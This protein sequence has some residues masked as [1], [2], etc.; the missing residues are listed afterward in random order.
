MSIVFD[1]AIE[2]YDKTRALPEDRHNALI[3][4]LITETR[5]QPNDTV[6]E[7]GIGTGR[8]AL[9]VAEHVQ[10]LYG[11][12]LSQ[13]MMGALRRKITSAHA[14]IDLAQADA[15]FLPFPNAT[16]DLVYAVHVYHLVNQWRAGIAEAW[17]VVKPGGHFVV[18]F[19][20][21][22]ADSPNSRLRRQM[23]V[24]AK[25]LGV[26]TRRPGS[27][28]EEETLEEMSKWD[29]NPKVVEATVWEETE[30]PAKILEELDRQIY[31]ETW[32]IPR[33]KMDLITPRLRE[34][35]AETFGDTAEPIPTKAWERWLVASKA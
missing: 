24:F 10:R 28:S 27:Q 5:V 32:A 4:A 19:H 8:I 17:R 15:V 29:P 22:E 18:S 16:F 30:I 1:R 13:E 9:S 33:D 2:Y 35:A 26:D 11:I 12:D 20:K 7:I 6:L 23:H 31:S 14:P 34:W 25:E 3:N 21:R